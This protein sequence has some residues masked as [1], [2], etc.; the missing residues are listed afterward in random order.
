MAKAQTK[1]QGAHPSLPCQ[2][3]DV[4]R[5]HLRILLL[6]V[7]GA[8]SFDDLRTVDRVVHPSFQEACKARYLIHH[9]S[10]WEQT[11]QEAC[12]A[13]LPAQ[14]REMFG[15][16]LLNCSISDPPSLWEQF[17]DSF[18]EDY[19]RQQ[20]S[21]QDSFQKA[22][23]HISNV[24][25][26]SSKR[27]EDFRLPP[28]AL[29][30]CSDPD[31]LTAAECAAEAF[32][33]IDMEA[34]FNDEQ[35]SVVDVILPQ[36]NMSLPPAPRAFFINGP[37]GS[38]KT[39]LHNYL[40][41]YVRSLNAKYM[42]CATT[43]IAATLI[44]GGRTVHKTFAIP[45]PCHENST[46]RISPSSPYAEQLRKTLLFIIDEATMLS[47]YQL[48]AI[49]LLMQ[50]I[51]GNKV[52]FGGK[53]FILSG[54]FRQILAV[55][56]R[57]T[58]TMLIEN[59]ILSSNLWPEFQRYDLTSNMRANP[60]EEEFK[61]FLIDMGDG[62]LPLKQN[63]PFLDTIEIPATFIANNDIVDSIFPQTE[64]SQNP[65]NILKRAILCP[66]NKESFSINKLILDR[67]PGAMRVY[68]SID[69]IEDCIDAEEAENYSIEF[70]NSLTPSGMPAH[71]LFLKEGAIVMLLRNLDTEKG[72]TNGTRLIIKRM[73]D[74]FLD[75]EI[76]TGQAQGK[77]VFI[78][79]MS[80]APSD[81]NLPFCLRRVQFPL[82]LAYAMTINKSQG[83]TFDNVG[84]Y[85]NRPCFSHGQLYVAFSRAKS[86]KDILVKVDETPEQ[87]KHLGKTYTKNVVLRQV[88]LS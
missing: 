16:M 84:I 65:D 54:D 34:T 69:T 8:L 57:A 88:L 19:L 81:T 71:N 45:V 70:L 21:P 12:V 53:P 52:I 67:L 62:K 55:L 38:G 75:A 80:L 56:R 37:G 78:P 4:E 18:S 58:P 27:L 25:R 32:L 59:T 33:H 86:H 46:C 36:L 9:D 74:L 30:S 79:K 31:D 2:P 20:F 61:S 39:Y 11:I 51:T 63:P 73:F 42:A 64:I 7:P 5:Y 10:V 76:L 22:L 23:S 28:L 77:R 87:G 43:G 26:G 82:R 41:H 6:N 40:I 24:L 50:D 72:L 60:D 15:Y 44:P 49:D 66:T 3:R 13:G 17:K 47:K 48:H 14:L 83:Q 68:P 85:L 29:P 35:R 1:P